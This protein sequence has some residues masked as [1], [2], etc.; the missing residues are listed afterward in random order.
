[1]E[2]V[3]SKFFITSSSAV[4]EV[5]DLN[6]FDKALI[7]AGI[8]EQ[9]L[10]SVSSVIP[11]G[12][13]RVEAC[14]MP[15]GAITHC[16]LAQMRGCEGETISAGIAY[17]Y[18]KDGKGGYVAEGHI[19]GSAESLKEILKWKME[20]MARIRDTEFEEIRFVTEE[21]AIPLDNYGCCVA[22]L[23]FTEYRRSHE[24]RAVQVR[25][26]RASQGRRP[27]QGDILLPVLRRFVRELQDTH[28]L[29]VERPGRGQG[30]ALP[31]DGLR[32]PGRRQEE[33]AHRRG[34]PLLHPR[35][36]IRALLGPR[37][38]DGHTG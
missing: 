10:V 11:V 2:L 7:K 18:R 19:H 8:G 5:S 23:V 35:L 28:L 15:M 33:G 36:Q 6:A 29:H 17:T 13:E 37:D 27:D 38:Q 21:L 31:G 4:S 22:A 26:V 9:N 30:G 12:A 20:E 3:P 32:P 14:E 16:V 34:R 1:M 24:V 25:H